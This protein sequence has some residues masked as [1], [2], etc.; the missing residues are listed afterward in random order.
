[1]AARLFLVKSDRDDHP[2]TVE[3]GASGTN[4]RRQAGPA[5]GPEGSRAGGPT[6]A[7]GW[8]PR[9]GPRSAARP[10]VPSGSTGA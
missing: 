3:G 9:A 5:D 8:Q 1:V 10:R 4:T 2:A 7:W 6:R